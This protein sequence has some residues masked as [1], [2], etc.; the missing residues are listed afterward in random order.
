[1]S[2]RTKCALRC[3]SC[4]MHIGRCLCESI[5]RLELDTK[6]AL[7]MHRR[8]HKKPTATGPLA[9]KAL[10]HSNI[11]IHGEKETPLDLSH[12]NNKTRRPLLLFPSE[13]A[14][15]LSDDLVKEDPRPITLIVP[16]GNWRQAKRMPK[17]IPGL[18]KIEHVILPEGSQTEW[19]I[20]QETKENGLA[21]FE[22]IS[23]AFG[24][25]ESKAAENELMTVFRLM[26]RNT[27]EASGK[28]S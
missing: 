21:T 14:R 24:I 3:L 6:L 19:G 11:Y 9:A 18:E 2:K 27:L 8:E 15:L 10:M 4:R 20:R 23:R 26:V 12:L 17:R 5:P 25:I 22:A 28:L 7:I 16:D 13:R 1:M